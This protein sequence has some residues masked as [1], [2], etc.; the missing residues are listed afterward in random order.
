MSAACELT[1][2]VQRG[3]EVAQLPGVSSQ[4]AARLLQLDG[5]CQLGVCMGAE[6]KNMQVKSFLCLAAHLNGNSKRWSNAPQRNE[7]CERVGSSLP[8]TWD[9][10]F[11]M[12][13]ASNFACALWVNVLACL[14]GLTV[15]PK[16]IIL[17]F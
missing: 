15:M 16:A 17:V 7:K 2:A 5:R 9:D 1:R 14:F 4:A 3:L 8:P 11:P 13:S 6:E 12:L 10:A